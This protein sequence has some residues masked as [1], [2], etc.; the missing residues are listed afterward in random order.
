MEDDEEAQPLAIEIDQPIPTESNDVEAPV[1]STSSP[2][3]WVQANS[4]WLI[5]Y[6]TPNMRKKIVVI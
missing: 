6:W 4:L 5:L 2:V 3:I 1:G